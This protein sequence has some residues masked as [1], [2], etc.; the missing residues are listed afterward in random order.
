[1]LSQFVKEGGFVKMGFILLEGGIGGTNM[2]PLPL[3]GG[4]QATAGK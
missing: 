3:L 4:F 2:G 1:M